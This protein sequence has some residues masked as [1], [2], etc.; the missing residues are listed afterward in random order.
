MQPITTMECKNC[1]KAYRPDYCRTTSFTI[2]NAKTNLQP[3]GTPIATSI[4]SKL[5]HDY[6]RKGFQLD[7]LT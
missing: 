1:N 2:K 7:R 5:I 3:W 6:I 4:R